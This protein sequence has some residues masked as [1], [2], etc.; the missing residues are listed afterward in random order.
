MSLRRKDRG[1]LFEPVDDRLA[2]AIGRGTGEIPSDGLEQ[3]VQH[4]L[5]GRFDQNAFGGC[6]ECLA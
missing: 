3:S 6:Q 1:L 2:I 5:I 4:I